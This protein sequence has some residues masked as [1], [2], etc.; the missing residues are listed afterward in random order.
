MIVRFITG[1]IAVLLLI[2]AG[3]AYH[4]TSS[5]IGGREDFQLQVQG[6]VQERTTITQI[7]SI[8]EYRGKESYAVVFGKNEAGTPVIA[9]LTEEKTVMDRLDLAVP[10]ENVEEAVKRDYPQAVVTGMVPGLDGEQR[11][12][13]VTLQDHDGRFHYLHYDLYNG[14]ILTSY[15]LSPV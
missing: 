12:W 7:D 9:W 8:D 10:K 2:A 6:W 14:Q 15:V 5:V 11:F 4:L 1:V 13:E 3:W